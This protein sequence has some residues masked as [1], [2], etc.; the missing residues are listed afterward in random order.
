M[1]LAHRVRVKICGI[2]RPEDARTAAAAGAD[3]IG[4]VFY[5]PSP[6]FVSVDAAREIVAALPPFVSAVGLLVDAAPGVVEGILDEVALDML[7]FHGEEP[8]ELCAAWGRPWLKAVRMRPGTDVRAAAEV[9]REARALLLDAWR[10]GTPGGTGAT[11]DWSEIPADLPR[12]VVLAGGLT[13]E[14]V[15][16]AL[17]RVAVA[18]VDVSGGVESARGIKDPDRITAFVRE[19]HRV[20]SR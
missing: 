20:Q 6:R 11:F 9:Y 14:N 10:P 17:Q 7:Q 1:T 3:A 15:G 2:T 19:V 18:A 16:A 12:P 13:P 8:P 5:P 4:L